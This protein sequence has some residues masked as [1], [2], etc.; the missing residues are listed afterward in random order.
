MKIADVRLVLTIL[1]L[2]EAT[3]ETISCKFTKDW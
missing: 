2:K 1:Q 3:H